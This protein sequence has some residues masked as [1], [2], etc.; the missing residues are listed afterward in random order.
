MRLTLGSFCHKSVAC[1][2]LSWMSCPSEYSI[3]TDSRYS[4]QKVEEEA[5]NKEEALIK[6]EGAGHDNQVSRD[7]RADMRG[8]LASL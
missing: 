2:A 6:A 8:G 7:E 3:C 4:P 1:Q 5:L